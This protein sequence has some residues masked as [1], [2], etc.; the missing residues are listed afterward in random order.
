MPVTSRITGIMNHH[1]ALTAL[2]NTTS[3]EVLNSSL[4]RILRGAASPWTGEE[5]RGQRLPSWERRSAVSQC[6]RGRCF[7]S[8]SFQGRLLTPTPSTCAC[9]HT[10]THFTSHWGLHWARRYFPKC[11]GPSSPR[12][13][14]L[15]VLFH[16]LEARPVPDGGGDPWTDAGSLHQV[17]VSGLLPLTQ[18]VT[19]ES[20]SSPPPRPSPGLGVQTLGV[21]LWNPEPPLTPLGFQCALEFTA[22]KE[23]E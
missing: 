20:L 17:T 5:R 9:T 21:P 16:N 10:H 14:C 3:C 4:P 6:R 23:W 11:R 13:S 8:Q 7:Q 2:R 12:G 22:I 19:R 15:E 18:I 1:E